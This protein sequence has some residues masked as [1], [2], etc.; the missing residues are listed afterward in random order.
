[1]NITM[2]LFGFFPS[3]VR[4]RKEARGTGK[5]IRTSLLK[6]I[7]PELFPEITWDT[8]INTKAKLR[9]LKTPQIDETFFYTERPTTRVVKKDLVRNGRLTYHFGYNP[10]LLLMKVVLARKGGLK[11]WKGYRQAR[12]NKWKLKDKSVR[13]YFGWRFFLHFK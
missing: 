10:I 13:S 5:V 11:I 1:M 4:V 8:W 9:G 6:S 7:N 12:K 2:I 3:D